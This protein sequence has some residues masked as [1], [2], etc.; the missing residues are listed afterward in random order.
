MH[1]SPLVAY[2]TVGYK[3]MVLLLLIYSSTVFGLFFQIKLS[4][5]NNFTRSYR[6]N[7]KNLKKKLKNA[8]LS[9]MRKNLP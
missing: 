6:L 4:A 8:T 7:F 9:K 1:L 5:F 3:A 2:P